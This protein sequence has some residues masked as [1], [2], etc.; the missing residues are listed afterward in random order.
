MRCVPVWARSGKTAALA[1][2]H[3]ACLATVAM[4][5]LLASGC[6]RTSAGGAAGAVAAIGCDTGNADNPVIIAGCTEASTT[7]SLKATSS[8][9]IAP[10][11]PILSKPSLAAA[12][13]VTPSQVSPVGAA[14]RLPPTGIFGGLAGL[15][16]ARPAAVPQPPA[17]SISAQAATAGLPAPRA[18]VSTAVAI[19]PAGMSPRQL[20]LPPQLRDASTT[21][22]LP[23][24]APSTAADAVAGMQAR[25]SKQARTFGKGQIRLA[26]A[27]ASAVMTYPEIKINEARV[28]EAK[29]GIAISE[30]GLYPSADLR[31][32]SG[33]NFSGSYEGRAVPYKT[34]SND[35]DARFDG[36]LILRQLVYDF[37]ATRS[38]I[39]RARYLRD[40]EKMK[41]REKIDDIAYRT[42]QNYLKILEQRSLLRLIDETIAA[43]VELARIVQAHNKEG[44]GTAADVSRVASR[45]VDVRAIRS[46]ISLQLLSAEDQFQRLTRNKPTSLGNVP[47]FGKLIPASPSAAIAQM[48]ANNPKLAALQATRQSAEKE[49]EFQRTSALPKF[50]LEVETE[51]KNFR[52]HVQGRTQ[53]EGRAMMAMRYRLMDGGLSSATDQQIRARI[54][55]SEM[56]YLNDREQLEADIRQAYRAIESSSRKARLVAEGV[57]ASRKV[58]ELYLEQFKA[59]KRTIFEL[60]DGQ[61]SFYT[62][63]RSQI[64]SQYEGRRAM[65]DILRATGELTV[66]LSK[67]G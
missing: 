35:V 16:S 4:L 49:L 13:L 3:G 65:F 59:G 44:H 8:P 43:H 11:S 18:P 23:G 7:G 60:L 45:L 53:T 27:V 62:A 48:M 28:R 63:S 30:A 26:D 25:E 10:S 64:E 9:P 58:R 29:A 40:A 67:R 14:G 66:A 21:G 19:K 55:G 52:S 2:R 20:T 41:L 46:D 47:E 61:M 6:M 39:E 51:S 42:S 33:G 12:P 38:D 22:S 24:A 5:A 32:A 17:G 36:G 57:N 34:A 31:L 1:Q 56:T 37:G 15:F 54:E 50:N